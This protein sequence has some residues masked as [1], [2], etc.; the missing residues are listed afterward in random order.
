M[1]IGSVIGAL[2]GTGLTFGGYQLLD[3]DSNTAKVTAAASSTDPTPS[4]STT[5]A[6]GQSSN[7]AGSSAS[8][9]AATP[10]TGLDI[11][12]LLD[13]VGPSVVAIEVGQQRSTSVRQVAAG[14]GVI[15]SADGLVLT[16]AHV[17]SLTDSSGRALSNPVITVRMAD[18]TEKAAEVVSS[19]PS[20]DL[21]VIRVRDA[22]A[23]KPAT[24][25]SAAKVR[26]G[27]DVIAIGNAL[28]LGADP[29]V[30]KGI[31]SA[32][33]RTLQVSSTVTLNGLIQ[34]DA[35]INHGNSGGALVN[36][37]GEVVGINTAGI[38]DAQNLGFA[39]PIDQAKAMIDKA[40]N[41]GAGGNGV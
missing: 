21:A 3:G 27:D 11:H 17:V 41:N 34:T 30:T 23:L 31:V 8:P 28:D 20:R 36:A 10:Q 14:S 13:K 37:S 7:S 33:D 4:V 38:P 40:D 26:V 12:D 1:V 35:A 19:D 9:A 32:K 25:G 2:L 22:A 15:V 16:N 39:I 29:T 24:L 6:G 18:G 5:V